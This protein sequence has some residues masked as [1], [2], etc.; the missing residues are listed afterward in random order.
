[1]TITSQLNWVTRMRIN[2]QNNMNSMER[3]VEYSKIEPE[4]GGG[5]TKLAEI[6]DERFLDEPSSLS[7]TADLLAFTRSEL[8]R[9]QML[10]QQQQEKIAKRRANRSIPPP[11]FAH[12]IAPVA[13]PV[14]WPET[15]QIDLRNVCFRYRPDCA[16]AI[17]GLSMSLPPGIKL[18]IVGRTGSGKRR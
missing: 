3:V 13:P 10:V 7:A 9:E 8:Q 1:M 14:S 16:L 6:H 17:K 12:K 15:G 4:G 5:T 11:P 2:V 18:G